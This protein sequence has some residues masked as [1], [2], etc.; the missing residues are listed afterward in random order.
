AAL[1]SFARSPAMDHA[2]YGISVN[3]VTPSAREH[4][5][6]TLMKEEVLDPEWEGPNS[7]SFYS[8]DDYLMMLLPQRFPG[9]SDLASAT[10]FLASDEA[11]IITGIDIP[12]DAGLRHKYP[13]W[14][15]GAHTGANIRDYAKKTRITRFGE[16]Q[17]R[18][19]PETQG[20][21]SDPAQNNQ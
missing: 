21:T 9:S 7:M 18:L 17:E 11:E 3:T 2:Q 5:L 14:T 4:Q 19:I 15:P 1:L 16:P 12:V 8:R 10:L 13:T 6:W 20:L